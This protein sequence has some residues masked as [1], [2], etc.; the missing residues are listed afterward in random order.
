MHIEL[1]ARTVCELACYEEHYLRPE[2]V[3]LCG[4]YT[5]ENFKNA[6]LHATSA[7]L[8]KATFQGIPEGSH[9]ARE[10]FILDCLQTA[11]LGT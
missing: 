10:T 2:V 1:R 6:R 9:I 7:N 11:K 8:E 3:A 4:G 5:D